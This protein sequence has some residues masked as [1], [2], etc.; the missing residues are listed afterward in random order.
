MAED[1][2]PAGEE[3]GDGG[4]GAQSGAHPRVMA[5]VPTPLPPGSMTVPPWFGWGEVL[6]V[7][8]LAAVVGLAAFVALVA[9]RDDSGRSEWQA[10]L[11]GRSPGAGLPGAQESETPSR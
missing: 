5:P 4:S 7:L 10:W 2:P 9:G 1:L 8:V 3:A 11:D 6:L